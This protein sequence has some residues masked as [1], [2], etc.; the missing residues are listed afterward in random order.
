MNSLNHLSVLTMDCKVDAV[1][2]VLESY[3]LLSTTV[4]GSPVSPDQWKVSIYN[5][6]PIIMSPQPIILQK[7]DVNHK[8]LFC[9]DFC[10]PS[11]KV[12]QD[13][14]DWIHSQLQQNR[15]VYCHCKSGKGR[16]ASVIAAY[17]IKYRGKTAAQSLSL[18]RSR[19]SS[20]FGPNSA[21]MRNMKLFEES[22]RKEP[23]SMVA[24]P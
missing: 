19:R 14:A 15:V 5:P 21:Q 7:E 20:V 13:G 12:L 23:A 10:P 2:S 24:E 4:A 11:F 17:Y 18:I 9:F 1:L 6:P 16:S 3:E 22:L 8:Q